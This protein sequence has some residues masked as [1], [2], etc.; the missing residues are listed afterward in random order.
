M[1]SS[2]DRCDSWA[3]MVPGFT[4]SKEDFIALPPLLAAAGVGLVT[5]DQ[6]G[7]YR[8]DGSDEPSDYAI[9]LLAGDV[10]EIIA[11]AAARFGRTD[12]PHLV[13]HSFGGLVAQQA[14]VAGVV[15][16]VDFVAFC[17][18][19]GALPPERWGALPHLMDALPGTHLDELWRVKRELEE[20]EGA[21]P[22]PAHIEAF[23][24][25][26]WVANSPVQ[27]RENGRTLM[28]QPSFVPA[29]RPVVEAGLPLTV[30]WG[31]HDDAW[32]VDMQSR[33]AADLGVPT[34][35]IAGVGQSPNA[36][37]PQAMVDAL[38]RAWRG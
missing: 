28:V 27:L 10:A 9:E 29:L 6:L 35:E 36:E 14:L 4:G 23:L 11:Q 16:P 24:R 12:E 5:F 3:V 21:A 15:R 32:P 20:D 37:A 13:G 33:M 26:R 30:M 17:T 8:S 7:Q 2:M 34:I 38:L 22:A 18:G 1:H 31:E 25:E 19:P